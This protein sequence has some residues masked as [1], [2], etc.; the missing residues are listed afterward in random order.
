[1]FH[2]P[3]YSEAGLIDLRDDADNIRLDD[4]TNRVIVG[5]GHGALGI[6]D[7]VSRAKLAA[8]KLAG[9]PEGFQID[10]T[11]RR[12]FVNIPDVEQIAVV[13]LKSY[14]Q[15]A[16]WKTARFRANFPMA[17][18]GTAGPVAVV[19]RHPA[20][21][22][23]LDPTTGAMMEHVD[24]C[25][26][27]DDVFFDGKRQQIYVS[28]GD[29]MLDIVQGGPAGYRRTGRVQ[30]ASGA[31]TSLFVPELDRLFVAARAESLQ[32][33]AA[34]LVFRPNPSALWRRPNDRSCWIKASGSLEG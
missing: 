21:L 4:V 17:L 11:T 1:M 19:F 25:S 5:Y 31:R 15:V 10:P 3:D 30:T 28:C 8:I 13:D 27:A 32:S 16:M 7:P 14:R 29:G 20:K 34:I 6:I 12:V 9:H 26:D 22:A 23:L 18:N 24:T 33:D 2:G